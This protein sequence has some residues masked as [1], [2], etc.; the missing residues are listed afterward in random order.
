V[1]LPTFR[2]LNWRK[3]PITLIDRSELSATRKRVGGSWPDWYRDGFSPAIGWSLL[4]RLSL[5]IHLNLKLWFQARL[6]ER[7]AVE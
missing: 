4:A 3:I 1:R 7:I 6:D 5:P 2:H